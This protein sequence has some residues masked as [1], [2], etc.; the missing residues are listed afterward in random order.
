MSAA[1]PGASNDRPPG[2]SQ[3]GNPAPHPGPWL[4]I[5]I[6]QRAA[7]SV[8]FIIGAI[9]GAGA[10]VA[11]VVVW[12]LVGDVPLIDLESNRPAAPPAQQGLPPAA[13]GQGQ[14]AAATLPVFEFLQGDLQGEI[15]VDPTSLQFGPDG[16]L[17]VAQRD[18]LI[19]VYTV[20]RNAAAEYEVTKSET[21]DLVQA[22]PNHDD[23]G[24]P[25]Q[26]YTERLVTGLAVAGSADAPVVY[27]SSSDPRASGSSGPPVGLD[28]NSG[29]ISRLDLTPAGWVKTDIVRGLPRSQTEHATNGLALDGNSELLYVAQGGNTNQGA[30]SANFGFLPEYALSAAILEVDLAAI[31]DATYDLP[32]LDDP[33]RPDVSPGVDENDPFGGNGGANQ[34]LV[35]E[36]GPVRI[37]SPGWR[38]PYDLVLT[39]SGRLYAF[40][41]GSN[42]GN[43]GQPI[44]EGSAGNCTNDPGEDPGE[45][46]GNGLRLVTEGLYGGHPNP[47][48]G[49]QSN[50]FN[51]ASPVP[52]GDASQCDYR[53]PTELLGGAFHVEVLPVNG[54]AEYT[55]S[56]FG[57]ALNGNLIGAGFAGYIQRFQLNADGTDDVYSGLLLG[58]VGSMPLDLTTNGDGGPFPGTIWVAIYGS[59]EIRVFEPLDFACPGGSEGCLEGGD[60]GA[61]GSWAALPA[62]TTPRGEVAYTEADGR[63]ILAAGRQSPVE[64]FDPATATW[65]TFDA[66]FPAQIDHVQGVVVGELVYYVGGLVV[67]PEPEVSTVHVLDPST[68]TFSRGA[69]MP[70][71]R[72]RGAG[73]VAVHEG[74]IYYAG[75]I[76]GAEAV[77]LFDVYDPATDTWTQLPDMPVARDHFRGAVVGGIFYAIGG[78]DLDPGDLVTVDYSFDLADPAATWERLPSPL[79]T[80]RGGH[81]SVTLGDEIIIIGGEDYYRHF[82]TVEAYNT[83]TGRWRTLA[84]LPTGRAAVEAVVL[85]DCVYVVGGISYNQAVFGIPHIGNLL[86]A[87]EVFS[88]GDA[89]DCPAVGVA[90]LDPAQAAPPAI[91]ISFVTPSDTFGAIGRALACAIY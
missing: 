51:G 75:G 82:N 67:W 59:D 35:V 23:D 73:A 44:L 18:G 46:Q 43:G 11:L 21:I 29:I 26:L 62:S 41:N 78:R 49:N 71:G 90:S 70:A 45:T 91:D 37:Y 15:S 14:Q 1:P 6:S 85:D 56:N 31:G 40:D 83:V 86:V 38:N 81:A 58:G 72:G 22:I 33:S 68:G 25:N 80:S 52:E 54:L 84:P 17:Y 10:L 30:P 74:K 48:R 32:T 16:R 64:V 36:D 66:P 12:G 76:R 47:T 27:V 20:V 3:H 53:S 69:D 34:A 57:G 7:L 50:T 61:G 28:T 77:T 79:P 42:E 39:Q 4:D 5:A 87:H 13:G 88:L 65:S 2:D 89:T 19:H 9:F 60:G 8:V 24:T 55:A 63:F